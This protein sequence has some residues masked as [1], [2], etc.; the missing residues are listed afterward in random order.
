MISVE[1]NPIVLDSAS[2][3]GTSPAATDGG[4]DQGEIVGSEAPGLDSSEEASVDVL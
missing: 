4:N 3:A 2:A 1:Q